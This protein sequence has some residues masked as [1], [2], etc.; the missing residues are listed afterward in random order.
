ML[1]ELRD[2]APA[3]WPLNTP[4][5]RAET[6]TILA[7]MSDDLDP[8][9]EAAAGPP[10]PDSLPVSLLKMSRFDSTAFQHRLARLAELL[11][12]AP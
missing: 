3:D 12:G 2:V 11:P 5:G 9:T 1:R 7:A 10:S 6:D 8:Q 4:A